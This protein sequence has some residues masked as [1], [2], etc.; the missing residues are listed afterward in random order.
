MSDTMHLHEHYLTFLQRLR[1]N[2][3]LN[4]FWSDGTKESAPPGD[5][6]IWSDKLIQHWLHIGQTD[7]RGRSLG[8]FLLKQ[9]TD[10]EASLRYRMSTSS[11]P[12]C[13]LRHKLKIGE[14]DCY[15]NVDVELSQIEWLSADA[16]LWCDTAD[17]SVFD[18][19]EFQL[20]FKLSSF[21]LTFMKTSKELSWKH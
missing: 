1:K 4:A 10:W 9:I 17:T 2:N 13:A 5:D 15:E 8:I 12:L 19:W 3:L 14:S 20:S 6:K 11:W 7:S 16:C 21:I 18:T